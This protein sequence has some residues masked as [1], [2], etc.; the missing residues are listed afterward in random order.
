V[1]NEV[2]S[3]IDRA[4]GAQLNGYAVVHRLLTV[5]VL[6][7]WSSLASAD[8]QLI[9]QWISD[10]DGSATFNEKH[11]Q[12]QAK[13]A[14]FLRDSMGRL[15]V[16]F[17]ETEVSYRLPN[18]T[19]VIEG[20]SFPISGFSETHPYVIVATTSSSIAIRSIEPVS[21][22]PIIVVYNFIADDKAWIYVSSSGSHIR[23]Y[24]RR[25]D[26]K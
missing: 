15:V 19:T 9:G 20:K 14:A 10:R 26:E 4:R 17:S 6:V 18:F 5:L 21:H 11:A 8:P 23:E 12:L 25:V 13:T 1:G 22:E 16:T 7:A 24:F 2:P 3:P